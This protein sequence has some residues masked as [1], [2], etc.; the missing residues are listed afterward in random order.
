MYHQIE[1]LREEIREK[2]SDLIKKHCEH[3]KVSKDMDRLRDHLEKTKRRQNQLQH[4]TDMQRREIKKIEQTIGEAEVERLAQKKELGAV[5]GQR[6]ILATQLIK[7]NDELSLLYEKIRVQQSTLQKGEIHYKSHYEESGKLKQQIETMAA[8][9]GNDANDQ[10][11]DLQRELNNLERELFAE[12][13]K[14]KS[15]SEELENP[16]NVHRW[17]KLEG[18]DPQVFGL[19][20]KIK[21]LQQRIIGKTERVVV[22]DLLIQRKDKV[23]TELKKILGRQPGPEIADSLAL[24][25]EHVKTKRAQCEKMSNE[26]Q[27]YQTKVQELKDE[28]QRVHR[29]HMDVKKKV[30]YEEHRRKQRGKQDDKKIIHVL[31][32]QLPRFTGGGFNLSI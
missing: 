22:K 31:Q 14:V 20:N 3:V 5:Q 13:H 24:Y 27:L 4:I 21:T 28:L 19:I 7:R 32:P 11:R 9:V 10:Y 26:L 29:T 18:S 8:E 6:N 15:L 1:N 17:R 2:D 16:M 25:Q 30:Y 12:K 23:Y